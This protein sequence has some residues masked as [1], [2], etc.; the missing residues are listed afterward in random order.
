[1]TTDLLIAE[2]EDHGPRV[3]HDRVHV[4]GDTAGDGEV[5][6]FDLWSLILSL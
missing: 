2:V 6:I 4:S 3:V 5:P 1:M